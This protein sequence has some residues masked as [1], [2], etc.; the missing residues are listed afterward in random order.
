MHV[1]EKLMDRLA[2]AAVLDRPVDVADRLWRPVVDP[3]PMRNL[4]SG[5]W[6]GHRLHPLLMVAP[7]GSM[8]SAGLLDVLGGRDSEA[9]ADRLLGV[10]VLT[11]APTTLAGWSDWTHA[12]PSE[13]R[14]GL[15]HAGANITAVLL[16]AASLRAR[17]SGHR[18]TGKAL[19]LLGLG[20]VGAGGYIGGHLSYV[21]G[22]GVSRTAFAESV[23]EWTDVVAETEL[24]EGRPHRETVGG[25]DV[26]LVR[27]SVASGD[28]GGT[29]ASGA[30]AGSGRIDALLDRCNH[31]GCSLAEGRLD[32]DAVEC[33]CHGSRFRLVDGRALA[34]PAA[35]AQ[36]AFD[37]RVR[38]GR[39]EIRS[40]LPGFG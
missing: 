2:G 3:L 12:S 10:A 34:G 38:D 33:R 23:D 18:L 21:L 15:V 16:S 25:V 40:R 26:L 4:L 13:K 31:L 11:A 35:S 9:S 32:G 1:L 36:P 27:R 14:L 39:V 24:A 17:K 28:S 30:S 6:L 5:T 29:G 22:V 37:T 8:V 20:A 7:L 19:S